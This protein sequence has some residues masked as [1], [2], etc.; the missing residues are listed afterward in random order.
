MEST[1]VYWIPLY[2]L[3]AGQGLTVFLVNARQVRNV[4]GRKNEV[5]DC[6]WL[7]RLMGLGLLGAFRPENEIC[8]L[9]ALW[10]HR[11]MLTAYP[12]SHVQHL[13]KAPWGKEIQGW[14][15]LTEGRQF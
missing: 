1:G 13:Q 6:Q 15:S 10:R 12:G 9:R 14:P 11:D 2:E 8:T 3:L 5:L 4:P 7:Q